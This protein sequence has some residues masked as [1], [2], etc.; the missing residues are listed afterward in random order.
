V[1]TFA[2]ECTP[3]LKCFKRQGIEHVPG[4]IGDGVHGRDY[5]YDPGQAP[6]PTPPPT[7]APT[8]A[9]TPLPTH[10]P[11]P[12]P[13]APPTHNCGIH[14]KY[15]GNNLG[16]KLGCCEGDCDRNDDCKPGLKCFKRD[17]E[18][19]VPGCLG[20]GL[21]AADYCYDPD[22]H[23]SP[24]T[25]HP[26][27]PPTHAPT[28]HPVPAPVHPPVAPPVHPPNTCMTELQS[29]GNDGHPPDAFPLGCCRGDCDSDHDC[30]PGLKCFF[31]QDSRNIPGC[32]GSGKSG[33]DYCYDP[34]FNAGCG[35]MPLKRVGNNLEHYAYQC[36]EGDC[37]RNS[38]CAEGLI[39]FQRRGDFA[40]VPGCTGHG[41]KGMDYCISPSD[42]H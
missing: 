32:L 15:V 17:D 42:L 18:T 22:A 19:H 13:V 35:N 40:P 23:P 33:M 5:C 10:P 34:S 3:G 14:L 38:D 29:S 39:C 28:P 1:L 11:V 24:P 6:P 12:A 8:H 21:S 30:A 37:D 20:T 7:H 26:T 16:I 31:R 4:C 36:C 2:L 27:H 25:P 41:T 9:P